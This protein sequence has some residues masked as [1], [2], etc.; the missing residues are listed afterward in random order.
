M[1]RVCTPVAVV[2]AFDGDRPHGTTV[3]AFMSLSMSPPLI[4]VALDNNSELLKVATRAGHFSV[5]VLGADQHQ[6]AMAF[7]R[8]GQDKFAGVSWRETNN[9]PHLEGAS[10]WLRCEVA[11]ELPG[12]DHTIVTGAVLEVDHIETPP[13]TYHARSFG[14]HHTPRDTAGAAT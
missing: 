11:A 14:T 5:N 8:K 2:T 4:A 9:S 7:A 10:V 1:A 6:L 13:L 12:G 3:S